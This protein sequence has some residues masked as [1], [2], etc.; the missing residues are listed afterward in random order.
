MQKLFKVLKFTSIDLAVFKSDKH[1]VITYE[2]IFKGNHI[3]C[4]DFI[5][6]YVQ[7][8]ENAS[9]LHIEEI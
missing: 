7:T 5:R 9:Q 3:E 4:C 8:E 6:T 1:T 2:I